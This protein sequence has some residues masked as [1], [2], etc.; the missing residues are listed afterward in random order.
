MDNITISS[1]PSTIENQRV[2]EGMDSLDYQFIWGEETRPTQAEEVEHWKGITRRIMASW[3]SSQA[4]TKEIKKDLSLAR[5]RISALQLELEERTA[6]LDKIKMASSVA[7]TFSES[8]KR[9]RWKQEASND[10]IFYSLDESLVLG[11][12]EHGEFEKMS[13][14]RPVLQRDCVEY[15]CNYCCHPPDTDRADL[16]TEFDALL[17]SGIAG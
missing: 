16:R 5:A 11:G 2:K 7:A 4:E 14:V 1:S 15:E 13:E 10:P 9:E 8:P 6:E 12:W 3:F 17:D